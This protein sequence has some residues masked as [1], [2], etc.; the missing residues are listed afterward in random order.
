MTQHS[1][2]KKLY[3]QKVTNVCRAY[4]LSGWFEYISEETPSI[5]VM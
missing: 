2:K 3:F 1:H 4:F 5:A